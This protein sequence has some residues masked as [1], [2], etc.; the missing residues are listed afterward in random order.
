MHFCRVACAITVTRFLSEKITKPNPKTN[1]F[2]KKYGKS[3]FVLRRRGKNVT[4]CQSFICKFITA[5]FKFN[6]SE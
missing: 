4:Y 2:K 6:I 3:P 5:R 1:E